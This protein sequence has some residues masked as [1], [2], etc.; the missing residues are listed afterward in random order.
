[1]VS[2]IGMESMVTHAHLRHTQDYLTPGICSLIDP[3]AMEKLMPF[4]TKIHT[5]MLWYC[6]IHQWVWW[7]GWVKA[8]AEAF[9]IQTKRWGLDICETSVTPSWGRDDSW[10]G[11]MSARRPW[12]L[13]EVTHG[14]GRRLLD[15]HHN[16]PRMWWHM[17]ER[18]RLYVF[19]DLFLSGDD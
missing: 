5:V 7:H 16:F 9:S 15:I 11:Q 2:A 14:W 6:T 17:G 12:P 13:S 18:I 8:T 19:H 1:M 4:P 3:A 10:V